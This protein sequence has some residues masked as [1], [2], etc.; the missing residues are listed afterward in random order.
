MYVRYAALC[1]ADRDILWL[2]VANSHYR[3]HPFDIVAEF[4]NYN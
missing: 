1:N 3:R 2:C 4:H